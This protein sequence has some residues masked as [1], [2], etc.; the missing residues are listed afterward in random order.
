MDT[1]RYTQHAR[2][3]IRVMSTLNNNGTRAARSNQQRYCAGQRRSRGLVTGRGKKCLPPSAEK[4]GEG[5]P[6]KLPGPNHPE[7][8][9][10]MLHM[11]VFFFLD[12]GHR[13]LKAYCETL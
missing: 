6:Y 2:A 5:E 8:G 4:K 13:S 1:Q 10:T 9:P 11:F 12:E 3:A 7:R